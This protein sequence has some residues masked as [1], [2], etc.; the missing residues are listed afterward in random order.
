MKSSE[1]KGEFAWEKYVFQDNDP[2]ARTIIGELADCNRITIKG[3]AKRE[4]LKRGLTYRFLGRW[5]SHPRY[6]KQFH[7]NSFALTEPV[8][9][10]GIVMYLC[11]ANGIG[12]KIAKAIFAEC[13]EDSLEMLRTQPT[14]VADRVPGLSHD[15]AEAAAK[16]FAA[17][18][19]VETTKLELA[20]LLTKRGFPKTLPERCIERWGIGAPRVIREDPYVLTTFSGVGFMLA[21]RLYLELGGDPGSIQ[22]QGMCLWHAARSDNNG[23]VWFLAS[24]LF[25]YLR[26]DISGANL[27]PK[28]ALEWAIEHGKLVAKQIVDQTW[29]AEERL[30]AHEA[31]IAD[32]I[33]E[34]SFE[35]PNWPGIM[36]S[37]DEDDGLPSEHQAIELGNAKHG[38]IGCLLG[39]PGT[40]K[41]FTIAHLIKAIG[42]NPDRVAACAPTG[43][44]AVRLTE[45]L[46]K[47]DVHLQAKTIH[48]LLVVQS[49]DGG[50]HFQHNAEN[51]LPYSYIFVDESSMIDTPLMSALLA[52][53]GNAHILFVGDPDQLSPVGPGAPLRDMIAAGVPHGHLKKI[54]RNAGTIVQSCA[55]IRDEAKIIWDDELDLDAG[56]NLVHIET[57]TTDQ[58]IDEIRRILGR[59]DEERRDAIWSY[60]I[61]CPINK[62]SQLGRKPLNDM[63][64]RLLNPYGE[65]AKT[66]PF[67][68]VD[69]IV[70]TKNG[71]LPVA[72]GAD[73]EKVRVMN[74][75]MAEVFEVSE[76]YT[77][78][79][80]QMPERYVRIP[81]GQANDQAEDAGDDDTGCNWEL[82]YAL[83]VHKS[84]GSEFDVAI[85]VIDPY[86]GARILCDKHWIY[87]AISRAKDYCI[88]IGP[89]ENAI[90]MCRKSHMWD[91]KTFLRESIEDLRMQDMVQ[92]WD[93]VVA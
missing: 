8:G 51:P 71:D 84:Q 72:G 83:S 75:E 21:D 6:G 80:V 45:S 50:W 33:H 64:Q 82:G 79:I 37:E 81:R 73:G 34:A 60:Q 61:L 76:R 59:A 53:R 7:F 17:D 49:V 68:V 5:I 3:R 40:G 78:A 62:N 54:R 67:R 22:R 20:G 16:M 77:Q 89:K 93:E 87:T 57:R 70:C 55:S 36:F 1:I 52:A 88:T 63:L 48:S 18:N 23:H 26:K 32:C 31:N 35:C 66:N 58:T 9:E 29:I 46:A 44:A 19:A 13:G 4:E 30:A 15:V 38:V 90:Q 12:R 2:E 11:R 74:G 91:R 85:I 43:K 65:Q 69:K 92:K 47:A 39:S 27:K 10:R 41:T 24:N 14:T 25:Q 42:N 28:E 56:K 86:A